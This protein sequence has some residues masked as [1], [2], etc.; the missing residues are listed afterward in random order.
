MEHKGFEYSVVQT[1][2]PTGWKR[3][4]RV[5]G[6]RTKVGS[7]FSR[8]LAINF[9]EQAIEKAGCAAAGRDRPGNAG[10]PTT[11]SAIRGLRAKAEYGLSAADKRRHG[12]GEA[13]RRVQR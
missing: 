1:A 4:I 11:K 7:A 9:A 2:N 6:K 13:F 8:A 12:S 3:I 5:D 10:P